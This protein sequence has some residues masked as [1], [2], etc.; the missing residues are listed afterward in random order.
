MCRTWSCVLILLVLVFSHT[1]RAAELSWLHVDGTK[2]VD[3]SGKVV[4]LRGTNLGGWLVEEMWMMPFETKPPKGSSD[5][6]VKDH[7][8]LWRTVEK[9]LGVAAT[10]RIRKALRDAWI[11]DGDFQRIRAAGLNCV[12]IPFTYDLLDEPHGF[13]WLDQAIDR[14][15][16]HG[17]YTI[18]DL[19]GAPGRQSGEH[20]TGEAD[21]NRLFKD[22]EMVKATENVWTRIAERY[23]TRPEVAAFDL[24]NEPMGALNAATAH[25]VHDCLYHAIRAVDSR[26]MIIVEDG[27]KGIDSFPHLGLLGWQNMVLSTHHYHFDAKS[28]DDHLKAITKLLEDAAKL[29]K[30]CPA[31]YFVGEFQL[32]P[33]GSP[34]TMAELVRRLDRAGHSWTVWTYKTA[35]AKGGGGMWGWHRSEKP[36][37]L[38][39]PFRDSEAELIRKTD[40]VRTERLTEDAGLTKAFRPAKP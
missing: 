12:R 16:A 31:P 24:L 3:A 15:K 37:D 11:S 39:D 9:R 20:H 19:H 18:L 32:E 8:S 25:H 23:K 7:I 14:A 22:P 38:L 40:Q 1:T 5:P 4:P 28:H 10:Q 6:E 35:M 17:L 30:N 26:H 27:Y 29:Q 21:V 36:F 13:D 2:I 33:N 34:E